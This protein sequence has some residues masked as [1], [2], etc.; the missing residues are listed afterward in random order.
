MWGGLL[1]GRSVQPGRQ[2]LRGSVDDLGREL[3]Q[4]RDQRRESEGAS[5]SW[6]N[7]LGTAGVGLLDVRR[8]C[9]LS[10]RQWLRVVR[11]SVGRQWRRRWWRCWWAAA[12]SVCGCDGDLLW[13]RQPLRLHSPRLYSPRCQLLLQSR[14]CLLLLPV[15]SLW[16]L[17]IRRK[18]QDVVPVLG[19]CQ[20]T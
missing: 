18:P 12:S 19:P 13:L 16:S 6:L 9:R 8:L 20:V 11:D 14:L 17:P 7:A 1:G 3:R 2:R 15:N 10:C 5:S 4:R